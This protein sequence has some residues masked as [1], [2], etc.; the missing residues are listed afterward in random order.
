MY[1]TGD[2]HQYYIAAN[3]VEWDYTPAVMDMCGSEPVNFTSLRQ[4]ILLKTN[5]PSL[6]SQ[7]ASHLVACHPELICLGLVQKL[8]ISAVSG[9]VSVLEI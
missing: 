1:G 8:G 9:M 6:A 2:V 3:E 5:R 4:N 7:K